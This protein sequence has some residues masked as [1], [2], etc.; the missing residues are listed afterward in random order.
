MRTVDSAEF[1][2]CQVKEFYLSSKT[3]KPTQLFIQRV[4]EL[5]PVVGVG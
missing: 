2:S 5:F 3:L 1:E 4:P